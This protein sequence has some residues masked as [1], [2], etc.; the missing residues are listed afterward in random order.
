MVTVLKKNESIEKLKQI[1]DNVLSK[2]KKG[3]DASK[4]SGIL[5]ID[6]DAVDLQKKMRDE[7]S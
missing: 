7:W 1:L 6:D 3:I 5:K 2:K 4:F